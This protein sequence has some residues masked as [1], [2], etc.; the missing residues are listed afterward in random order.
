MG[1]TMTTTQTSTIHVGSVGLDLYDPAK[2]QLV[3]RGVATKTLD[4]KAK[5]DKRQKNIGKGVVKLLKNYPPP[6]PKS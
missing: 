4:A 5:P 3:W 6:I 2:K 1:S